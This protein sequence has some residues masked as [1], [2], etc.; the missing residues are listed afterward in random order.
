MSDMPSRQRAIAMVPE[1]VGVK[2]VHLDEMIQV[3]RIV[4]MVARPLPRGEEGWTMREPLLEGIR[5]KIS[6]ADLCRHGG[7]G[8]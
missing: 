6:M 5:A 7:A 2:Q 4:S 1:K 3:C 8:R